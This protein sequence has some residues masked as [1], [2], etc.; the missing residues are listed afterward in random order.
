YDGFATSANLLF[1]FTGKMDPTTVNPTNVNF[2]RLGDGV[3]PVKLEANVTLMPDLVHVIVTPKALPL[4][5]G[6]QYAVVVRKGVRDADGN[7]I[8]PMPAAFLLTEK[9]IVYKDG[10]S[11]VG[12]LPAEDA[13]RVEAARAQLAPVL[14]QMGREDIV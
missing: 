11:L 10:K 13:V 1:E 4:P 7:A 8:V 3:A 5:E 14:D 2:Y 12:A 9:S 6:T